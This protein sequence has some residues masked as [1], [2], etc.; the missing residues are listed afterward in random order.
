MQN[1]QAS[2]RIQHYTITI[3][4]DRWLPFD[5]ECQ[6]ELDH[7]LLEIKGKRLLHHWGN[8]KSVTRVV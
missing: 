8:V 3:D 6:I 1:D 4:M 2:D 7:L 5:Q